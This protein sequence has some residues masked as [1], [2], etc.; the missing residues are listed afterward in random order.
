MADRFLNARVV[1]RAFL[2]LSTDL[3]GGRLLV[4]LPAD[5]IALVT[6]RA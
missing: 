2:G 4:D 3:P 6:I 5:A 1:P